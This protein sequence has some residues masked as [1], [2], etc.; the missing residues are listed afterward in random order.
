MPDPAPTVIKGEQLQCSA[1]GTF[2]VYVALLRNSSV[3]AN[4]TNTV[5]KKLDKEG[6]YSCVATNKFGTDT[7]IIPVTTGNK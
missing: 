4:T 1:T 6:N 7:R 5:V 3:L 2:P